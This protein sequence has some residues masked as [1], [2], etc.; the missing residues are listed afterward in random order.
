M[1]C[2]NMDLSAAALTRTKAVTANAL[3]SAVASLKPEERRSMA[4]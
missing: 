1:W 4:Q 2:V 3:P